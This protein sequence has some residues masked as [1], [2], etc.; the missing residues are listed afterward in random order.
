MANTLCVL[1]SCCAPH[2]MLPRW[3]RCP[4]R[5]T[6]SKDRHLTGRQTR[7]STYARRVRRCSNTWAT[8]TTTGLQEGLSG[9]AI[10]RTRARAPG[11]EQTANS[12]GAGNRR[13]GGHAAVLGCFE[14]FT[15]RV[16]LA[17][18]WGRTIGCSDSSPPLRGTA[19]QPLA[20]FR[21]RLN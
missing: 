6:G 10:Q 11:C 9:T 15:S 5:S 18:R 20:R 13:L 19:A 16:G 8:T 1:R 4:R 7:T 3:Y 2:D 14:A 12:A 17:R 21:G